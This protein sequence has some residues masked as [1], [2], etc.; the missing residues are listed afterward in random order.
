MNWSDEG[1]VLAVR[2]HGEADAVLHALTFEHGRHAGLVKGGQGRAQRPLL[3]PGNVLELE[4]RARLAEH[5]GSYRIEPRRPLAAG[6]LDDPLR[7]AALG[8]ACA[9]LEAALP[10]RDPHPRVYA[11]L[12]TW[13]GRL[14]GDA[15]WAA[16]YVRLEL[17]LLGELGFALDLS[18]CALTG[19]QED[20]AFVSPRSGRAVAAAAAAPYRDRLLP[21]PAFLRGGT[22]DPGQIAQGLRLAGH[23]LARHILGPADRSLPAA[24]DRLAALLAAEDSR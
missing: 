18:A 21:L 2:R 1:I 6:L 22:S 24:R 4:W 7:L 20:L 16:D 23:F 15:E 8:A 14:A 11:A 13:L 9:L 19:A 17:L 12:L 5:L 3:Q 10:E